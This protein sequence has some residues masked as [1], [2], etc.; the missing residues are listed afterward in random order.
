MTTAK[1][2]DLTNKQH[3]ILKQMKQLQKIQSAYMPCISGLLVKNKQEN[4]AAECL[5]LWMPSDLSERLHGQSCL[6]G[7]VE[8]ER[9]FHE[10]QCVDALGEIRASL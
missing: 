5:K 8:K 2:Q 3:R 10:A 9:Q 4:I 6:G 1:A 7:V